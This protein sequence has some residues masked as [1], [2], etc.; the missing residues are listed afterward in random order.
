MSYDFLLR[1][2]MAG[3]QIKDELVTFDPDCIPPN[4]EIARLHQKASAVGK[5]SAEEEIVNMQ[6][7]RC[8]CC[9]KWTEKAPL[10]MKV[11]PLK[12]SFLGTGVPLFFDFIKQ[13]I[14][15]LI[16]MFCTSGDYNLITNIAFGTSCQKDLDDTNTSDNCDLNYITQSSLANKRLDSSLM[17]LQQMLNLVSIF[18]IIILLQYIRIQQRTI[19]RDCDFHTTTPSDFGVKLSHIPVDNAGQIK[20][21]LSKVLNEFLEKNVPY[22]P[23]VLKYMESKMKR[24]NVK[25]GYKIPPRIHS[26][27]LCYDISKYE[28]LNAKK[29]SFVKEKQKYLEKMYENYMYVDNEL[30]E[31]EKNLEAGRQQVKLYFD[32]FLD[33]NSEQKEF[34]GIAFVTFQWEADQEAFINL[35]RTTVWGRYFGEQTKIFLD[36][37][38]IVV[39]EAPEPNDIKDIQQDIERNLNCWAIFNISKL[40]QELLEKENLLLKKLA[41]LA[42]VIIIFINY[43][44]SYSIKKIAAFQGFSTNTGHH[45]S[46]A[47]SAGIAQ[48]VN[49]ALVTWLVFTLLFDENYYKDGGLI[50]NQTYVFISNMIIPAVTAILDPFYWLKVYQRYSEEQKGKYSV[51]TQEQ[52]HKLFENNEETLSDR[53]AGIIKTMLMTSFYA[54][55]IPLGILFSIGA[56]TLLYWVY[57]YQFLRRRTFKQSL[58]FNL[59]IEM[60]EVLEYMIPIYCFSNFWFQYTFTKGKDVSSFAIIGVVIGIVNAVLPCYELNQALFIIEDYEQVTRPYKKIEKSLDSDYSRNNPATQDQA[61]EK[62]IQSMR[63]NK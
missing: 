44:L 1:T 37:Q 27:T 49:S 31:I 16:I 58:S 41:S 53:Y 5:N 24:K 36:D 8:P 13:C 17:N 47:T 35:N 52:L 50:Y 14:T 28:Q 3:Q 29:E 34:V 62:F 18:I 38:N 12:L 9:L 25:K 56:L 54:S 22:D 48:F 19:L 46:I 6:E 55:I 20:D 51:C 59:S 63:V 15:I 45:I 57:K 43:L 4:F 60:T 23:K 61:K 30:N 2:I 32:Q 11:S 40:Q 33:S 21:R 42:S 7:A 26:I 10:S 39:D